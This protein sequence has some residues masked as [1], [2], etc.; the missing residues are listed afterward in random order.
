MA[1]L[2]RILQ[3]PNP[4]LQRSLA[5]LMWA[6]LLISVLA[7]AL[8]ATVIIVSQDS[9]N[10]YASDVAY[11]SYGVDR[12]LA[13]SD[14]IYAAFAIAIEARGWTYLTVEQIADLRSYMRDN[15]TIF[16]DMHNAMNAIIKEQDESSWTNKC[17]LRAGRVKLLIA[18]SRKWLH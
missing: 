5:L 18:S 3:D 1:R 7:V 16:F 14:A 13:L 9:F 11:M 2:R 10:S 4:P 8:S 6:G 15:A 12:L 17:K